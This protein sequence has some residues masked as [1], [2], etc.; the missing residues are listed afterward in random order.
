MLDSSKK[1]T[2]IIIIISVKT[3]EKRILFIY[4][5]IYLRF[6]ALKH[7]KYGNFSVKCSIC[8]DTVNR[9]NGIKNREERVVLLRTFLAL[10]CSIVFF[11][12]SL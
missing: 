12:I 5:F 7:Q 8:F 2:I 10:M 9:P 6:V 1:K 4:L 3:T 11:K